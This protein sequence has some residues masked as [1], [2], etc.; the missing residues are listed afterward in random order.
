MAAIHPLQENAELAFVGEPAWQPA[1]ITD[2]RAE[3]FLRTANAAG[4]ANVDVLRRY[5]GGDLS[6]PRC[7]WQIDFP[8]HFD[9]QEALLYTA[10]S[11]LLARRVRAIA[12]ESSANWWR[13]PHANEPLRIAAA[14]LER[15]LAC[16]LRDAHA[17]TPPEWTWQE[18]E[19]LPDDT[20]IAVL[21]DDDFT[22][23]LLHSRPFTVWW[24]KH[25]DRDTPIAVLAAF[26]FPWPPT[27]P[28]SALSAAQQEL[29]GRMSRAARTG[30]RD[31][32][33]SV[34]FALYGFTFDL[35]DAEI[36]A[37]LHELHAS[38]TGNT[39]GFTRA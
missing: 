12:A 11:R 33:D 28:F 35:T 34:A 9:E 7:H 3:K 4:R 1:V 2:A 29:R 19:T 36:L 6:A 14:R 16:S 26:P 24:T 5:V 31:E 13:N 38:R 37:R 32:I 23:G 27:T 15:Y 21:R 20:L 17:A 30:D 10:P 8:P 22:H 39:P 18:S 25:F